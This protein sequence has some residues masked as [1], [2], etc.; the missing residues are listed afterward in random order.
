MLIFRKKSLRFCIPRLEI[1][2]P[3]YHS[4]GAILMG[5]PQ[6]QYF[7]LKSFVQ[8]TGYRDKL[9]CE[10]LMKCT[11]LT[12]SNHTDPDPDSPVSKSNNREPWETYLRKILT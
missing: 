3:V 9:C 7:C 4:V 6:I 2:Q 10:I 5:H 8:P 11:Y 1:P 12:A